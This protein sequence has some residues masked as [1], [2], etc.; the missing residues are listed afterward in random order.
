MY[1]IAIVEDQEQDA[2]RL[3]SQLERYMQAAGAALECTWWQ[4][5]IEFLEEYRSQYDVVFMDIDMPLM[6]GMTAARKLRE[7]DHAV[8]LVFLTSLSQYAVAGYEVEAID[9]ILKPLTWAA[10]E[11]KLP[12]ILRRCAGTGREVVI[13]RGGS[14]VRLQTNEVAY[15]EIY[16]HHIQFMTSRGVVRAYGTLKEVEKTL[17]E[18]FFRLNNQTIVNLRYVSR[19]DGQ[20]AVVAERTF[21]ISRNRR[22]EFLAALHGAM[23]RG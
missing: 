19:V 8:L 10:L 11:L 2:N 14:T 4:S 16:D 18:G 9:Y 15:V 23:T 6:D 3:R 20:E 5:P 12:R 21:L 17:P 1:R 13:Q 22:K 7:K